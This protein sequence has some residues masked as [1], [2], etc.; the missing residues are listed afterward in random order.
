[1]HL[2]VQRR[3]R[4]QYLVCVRQRHLLRVGHDCLRLTGDILVLWVEAVP[5]VPKVANLKL[6]LKHAGLTSPGHLL[7]IVLLVAMHADIDGMRC[8]II[9]LCQLIQL[10]SCARM[11]ILF[12]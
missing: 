3:A 10:D 12:L 2:T 9:A 6:A 5:H 4:L 11:L 1:V 8:P 7:G